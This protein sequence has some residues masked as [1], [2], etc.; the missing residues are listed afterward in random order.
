MAK[1]SAWTVLF[2][3][4]SFRLSQSCGGEGGGDMKNCLSSFGATRYREVGDKFVWFA[5][6]I[7]TEQSIIVSPSRDSLI[8]FATRM[9]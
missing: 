1:S 9:S 2:G 7:R 4:P 5:K 6:Y 3:G 8:A